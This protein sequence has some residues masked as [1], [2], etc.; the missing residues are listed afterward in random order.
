MDNQE[1]LS[2]L[3]EQLKKINNIK[4]I[5]FLPYH[6]LGIEKYKELNID[7]PLKSINAMDS[8]E[9]KKLYNEFI[10]EINNKKD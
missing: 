8:E 6:T 1:Y 4:K 10:N 5:E 7:Y 9:C 3:K 2:K